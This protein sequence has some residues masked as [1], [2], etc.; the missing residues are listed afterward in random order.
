VKRLTFAIA[1]VLAMI[2]P[3]LRAD[4]LRTFSISASNL[5]TSVS[6]L[7][8]IDT[9]NG[10]ALYGYADLTI[11]RGGQ[12]GFAPPLQSAIV[13]SGGGITGNGGC[14]GDCLEY[15]N[16]HSFGFG[17]TDSDGR[18]SLN[19]T[20]P[21]SFVDYMGGRM[22]Y[23]YECEGDATSYVY[24]A[25]NYPA[26]TINGRQYPAGILSGLELYN[27]ATLS[28]VSQVTTPEPS[29]LILL[30]SGALGFVGALRRRLPPL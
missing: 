5:Y 13:L 17:A 24:F 23:G 26:G 30:A 11:F 9:T 8:V 14:L 21:T 27:N 3:A 16:E 19:M 20:A 29:S 6:G 7:V 15:P 22:C 28:Y 2:S 18:F 4:T 1:L 10:Q 25:A 12:I